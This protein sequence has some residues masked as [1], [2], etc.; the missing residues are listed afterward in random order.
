MEAAVK[1]FKVAVGLEAN[2]SEKV[3]FLL[4]FS[5]MAIIGSKLIC[6]WGC[7]LGALQDSIHGLSPFKQ[8]KRKQVPFWLANGVH[9]VIFVTERNCPK[10]GD[11]SLDW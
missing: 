8:I 11:S 6:G 10:L 4:L 9:V 2:P 3:F 5:I 7:Q 1:V